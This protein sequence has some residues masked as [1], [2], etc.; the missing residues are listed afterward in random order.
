MPRPSPISFSLWLTT[1]AE[2]IGANGG[3]SYRTP[4]LDKLAA[5]GVRFTHC[6]AQPLCTPTRVQLITGA[7]N[8]RNYTTF[9]AMDPKLVTFGNLLQQAGYRTGIAGKWQLNRGASRKQIPIS[10]SKHNDSQTVPP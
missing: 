8:V 10:I 4:V 9:G 3:T 2:T 7:Y 1:S 6:Y 5:G